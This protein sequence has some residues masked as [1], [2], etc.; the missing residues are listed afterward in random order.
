MPFTPF[1]FGPGLLVKSLAGRWFSLT[2]FVAAQVLIDCETLYYI[3]TRQYPL[4]RTLHTFLGATVAG[5]GTGLLLVGAAHLVLRYASWAAGRSGAERQEVPRV[6]LLIGGLVGGASHP[7][8]DGMMHRDVRPF[9]PL[10]DANPF[11]GMVGLDA[12]H[13]SCVVAGL[14]GLVLAGVKLA[15]REQ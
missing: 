5:L 9:A 7:L 1:H 4:H 10:T 12:L 6:S 8:L 2:A 14:V 15:R 11:L 3:L 13:L